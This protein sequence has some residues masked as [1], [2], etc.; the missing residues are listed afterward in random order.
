LNSYIFRVDGNPPRCHVPEGPEFT[1]CGIS[2]NFRQM[3]ERN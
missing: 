3:L 1:G 2:Y